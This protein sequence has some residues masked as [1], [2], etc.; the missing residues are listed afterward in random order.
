MSKMDLESRFQR[1]MIKGL[2]EDLNLIEINGECR[3]CKGH[4]E[5]VNGEPFT[6]LD[7]KTKLCE[8]CYRQMVEALD[9]HCPYCVIGCDY[10]K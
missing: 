6:Y 7:E 1:I 2:L 10:C 9:E 3:N 5:I 8:P 4:D